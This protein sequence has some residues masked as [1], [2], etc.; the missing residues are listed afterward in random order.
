[1]WQAEPGT[2][3]NLPGQE[4]VYVLSG[5]ATVSGENGD[6]I[7]VSAGDLVFVDAGEVATWTVHETLRKVFVIN[8]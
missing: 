1:M 3:G 7:D 5:K 6:S 4:T 8:Q 2:H